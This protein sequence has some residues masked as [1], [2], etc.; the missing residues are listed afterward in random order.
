MEMITREDSID[1]VLELMKEVNEK[2]IDREELV[3]LL[4]LCLFSMHHIFL[5]GEPGVSKTGIL[6]IFSTV[7]D[8]ENTFSITIKNDTK[9]EEIF[10]D[11]YRDETGRLV[12]DPTNSIVESVIAIIDETWKGNSKVMNS[13]LSIMSPYRNIDIMGKGSIK[14]PLIMVGGASNELPTDKEVRPLRDRFLFSYRVAKIVGQEDWVKFISRDYDRDPVLKTKFSSSEIRHINSQTQNVEMSESVKQTFYKIRQK[15]VLLEIGVS[16]RKFDG[17]V[18]VFKTSAY[19][20]GRDVVGLT[21]LFI[22]KHILWE[23]ERDIRIIGDILNNEIFGKL[24]KIISFVDTLELNHKKLLS[25]VNGVLS[26]FL[27]FRRAYE[28]GEIEAF[29]KNKSFVQYVA[30]EFSSLLEKIDGITAHYTQSMQLEK[31]IH[32]NLFLID[33]KSPVYESFDYSSVVQ[34]RLEAYKT[35]ERL[36]DWIINNEELYSYNAMVNSV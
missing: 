36:D 21:E 34:F 12:Y 9:Y 27:N 19:L 30:E 10:G 26:D 14:A 16:D 29:E 18:D 1:R 8:K 23:E 20:N 11:R 13:F 22:L 3:Q 4:V 35:K 25:H 32:E 6:N 33:I 15:V 17:A 28:Y 2:Q 24:D 5:L 7:I 31:D